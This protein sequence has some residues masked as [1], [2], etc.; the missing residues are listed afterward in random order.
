VESQNPPPG[1]VVGPARTHVTIWVYV[2][3]QGG[4]FLTAD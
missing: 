3:A 2:N 4:L 1:T